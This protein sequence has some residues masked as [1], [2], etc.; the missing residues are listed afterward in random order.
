MQIKWKTIAPLAIWLAIYLIPVPAGLNA[1]QFDRE[2]GMQRL[3]LARDA[4]A[5]RACQCRAAR[6]ELQCARP[7]E[8]NGVKGRQVFPAVGMR[9]ILAQRAQ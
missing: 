6:A 1:D 9:G 2:A 7:H 4:G 3:E 5:L 8:S